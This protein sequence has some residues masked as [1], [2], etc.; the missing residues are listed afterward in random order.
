MSSNLILFF[1]GYLSPLFFSNIIVI[2]FVPFVQ[3]SVRYQ[4]SLYLL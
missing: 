4:V 1:D 2:P 3:R